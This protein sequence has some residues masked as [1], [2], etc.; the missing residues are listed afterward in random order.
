MF[1]F[2]IIASIDL[3]FLNISNKLSFFS[4]FAKNDNILIMFD[5]FAFNVNCVINNNDIQLFCALLI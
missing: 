1:I 3:C 4:K 5:I 2:C